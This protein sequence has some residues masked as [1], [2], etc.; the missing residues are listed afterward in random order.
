MTI[1]D[2]DKLATL[3]PAEVRARKPY[4][5]LHAE[6]LISDEGYESL[7]ANMPDQSTFKRIYGKRRPGGQE[8]HN[9]YALQYKPWNEYPEPWTQLI[10]DLNGPVYRKFVAD[11]VGHD[12][13]LL[14]CHWHYTPVGCS[15]SPHT[16]A[17]WKYGSHIFY[18]NTED[19]WQEDWGGDTVVLDDGGRFRHRSAPKFEDFDNEIVS[20][21]IGNRSLFFARNEHSW[22]GVRELRCP[23]DKLRKVFIVEIRRPDPIMSI[24]TRLGF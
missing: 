3:D 9:R 12:K 16:D 21:S 17:P 10:E 14:H 2:F 8:P 11:I 1:L 5:W 19:D 20:P 23:E 15:V 13:F 6:K 22:H 4:P 24:R 7:L 18:L